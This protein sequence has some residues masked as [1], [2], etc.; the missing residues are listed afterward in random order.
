LVVVMV[1]AA[2]VTLMLVV[3]TKVMM[4]GVLVVHGELG[5]ETCHKHVPFH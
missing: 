5:L 3:K 2:A 1:V 4:D